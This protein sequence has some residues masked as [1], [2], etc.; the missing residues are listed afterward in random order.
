MGLD[1]TKPVFGFS[2]KPV[3]SATETTYKLENLLVASLDMIFSNKR[4]TKVLIRLQGCC[5]QTTEDRFSH[6]AALIVTA[7]YETE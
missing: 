1:A 6:V 2:H 7:L 4:I 5:L 3:S